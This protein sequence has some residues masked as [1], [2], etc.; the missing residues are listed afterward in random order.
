MTTSFKVNVSGIHTYDQMYW[1]K[2]IYIYII[3]DE[4]ILKTNEKREIYFKNEAASVCGLNLYCRHWMPSFFCEVCG[5]AFPRSSYLKRHMQ[6]QT[7][8]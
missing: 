2:G 3:F 5:C 8:D 7:I 4:L 1:R 6:A